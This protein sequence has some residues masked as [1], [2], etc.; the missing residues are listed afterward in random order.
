M[1]KKGFQVLESIIDKGFLSNIGF[2][3]GAR[4]KN[5]QKDYNEEI[6]ELC[7]KNDVPY[8][9][10]GDTAYNG[11]RVAYIIAISWRWLISEQKSKPLIVLHDSLLPKYRGFAP[12]VNSLVNGEREIGVSALFASSE[13]DKGPIIGQ[14][15]CA[16]E[17]P[18]KIVDAIDLI[19]KCYIELILDLFKKIN[20]NAEITAVSQNEESA[21]YSLWRDEDD[22]RI[23]W[24]ND[25]NEIKRF[26]D[27][28]GYPYMGA[29]T[30][31][32]NRKVRILDAQTQEDVTVENRNPGKVIFVDQGKPVIVCGRGL[33]K[34]EDGH[35]DDTLEPL[36]PLQNFRTKFI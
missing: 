19:T 25:S 8:F 34:I 27:S 30:F 17:Y 32:K 20:D 12:L 6:R 33:L 31:I 7:H 21:T 4:D 5:V 15:K 28:V 23:D 13:Y 16:I 18:I 3:V 26:I 1:A 10:K 14:S 35:F 22:Y 29:S 9:D 24:A 36:L 2:V 11:L